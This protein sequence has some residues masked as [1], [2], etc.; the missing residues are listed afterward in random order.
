MNWFMIAVSYREAQAHH[1]CSVYHTQSLKRSKKAF[2][3]TIMT[4]KNFYLSIYLASKH[5]RL[6]NNINSCQ[7]SRKLDITRAK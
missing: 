7:F 2:G 5:L 3:L 6:A 1:L 4:F